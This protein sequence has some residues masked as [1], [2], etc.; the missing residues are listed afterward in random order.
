MGRR[1]LANTK[2]KRERKNLGENRELFPLV[3]VG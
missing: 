2:G 1:R 3:T